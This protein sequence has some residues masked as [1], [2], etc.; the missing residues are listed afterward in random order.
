MCDKYACG[1]EC[2]VL[3]WRDAAS[4]SETEKMPEQTLILLS[5]YEI[6]FF[7]IRFEFCHL[8]IY[9]S[10]ISIFARLKRTTDKVVIVCLIKI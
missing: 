5:G 8:Y 9:R 2:A 7:K 4:V 10:D 3:H 1:Q 6:G